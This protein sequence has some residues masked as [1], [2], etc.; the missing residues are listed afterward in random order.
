MHTKPGTQQH[1]SAEEGS[2][3]TPTNKDK[4]TRKKERK[5]YYKT[6]NTKLKSEAVKKTIL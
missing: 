6:Q 2:T 5:T 4:G 1:T 3:I